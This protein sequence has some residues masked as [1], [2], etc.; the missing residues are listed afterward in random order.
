[1]SYLY[2]PAHLNFLQSVLTLDIKDC[3]TVDQAVLESLC[4]LKQTHTAGYDGE[5]RYFEEGVRSSKRA[6]LAARVS[7][8]LKTAFDKQIKI[9]HVECFDAAKKGIAEAE[10]SESAFMQLAQR[11]FSLLPF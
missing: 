10:G 8:E 6:E 9:L 7:G 4:F 11:L 5:A 3:T 2:K 1:M